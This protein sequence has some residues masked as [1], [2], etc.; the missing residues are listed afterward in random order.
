L[1]HGLTQ[2]G[3]AQESRPAPRRPRRC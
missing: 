3:P 2:I 1:K